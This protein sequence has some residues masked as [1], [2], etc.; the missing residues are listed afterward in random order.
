[1]DAAPV[2]SRGHNVA[3]FVPP[4]TE[5]ALPYIL[6][7]DGRRTLVISADADRAVALADGMQAALVSA[8]RPAVA[9]SGLARAERR[10]AASEPDVLFAGSADAVVL[11]KRS[12]LKPAAFRA[13]VVAWPEQLDDDGAAALESL[14][15][16]C[17]KEA[18]RIILSAEPGP[19]LDGLIERYAFKAMT[20]GFPPVEAPEGWTP[21]S[22]VG[23]A[24]YV[25]ARAGQ[26]AAARRR[27][28]DALAPET[29]DTVV[30]A[31]CPE[32]RDAAEVLAQAAAGRESPVLIVEAHQLG[33]IRTLFSPLSSL[34]LPSAADGVERHAESVR[35]AIARTIEKQNL[36]RELFLVGPLLD[37]FDPAV[38]AAAALRLGIQ[39]GRGGGLAPGAPPQDASELSGV[40]SWA[41]IWV[42]V[43][44]KDNVRPGDLVGAIAHQVKVPVEAI[45]KI[46]V[47]DL[48]CLVEIRTDL[49]AKVAAD[50]TG[51][52]LKGRRLVARVDR[53]AG[54]KPPRRA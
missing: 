3:A 17:D 24:R 31:P 44:R 36:D 40:L 45:G 10:L 27:V 49:A 6:Q 9:V 26:F 48:F 1:V 28:L 15:A 30:I 23:P 53:G 18:Q 8:G 39:G 7:I 51:M 12:V 4:V 20:F 2:I 19:A 46:E 54:Q 33:W 21:P 35:T 16:E 25:I 29:D 47:R 37:R 14:L 52:T 22:P 38:V 11:L 13:I 32:S 5:A 42:G 41:K 43:G 50:L 34:R